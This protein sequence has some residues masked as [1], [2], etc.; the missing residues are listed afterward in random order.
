MVFHPST[1]RRAVLNVLQNAIEAMTEALAE[2]LGL[3][4]LV[5]HCHY[6]LGTRY[7][8]FRQWEQARTELSTAIEMYTSMAMTFWLPQTEAALAQVAAR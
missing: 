4:P 7:A 8:T 3:R 6:G 5:A 1:L 2:E